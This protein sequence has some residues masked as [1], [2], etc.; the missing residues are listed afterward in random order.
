MSNKEKKEIKGPFSYSGNKFKIWKQHLV[1]PFSK[2]KKIIEPFAGSAVA[3]Y[4]SQEGGLGVDIDPNVFA[5][6]VSLKRPSYMG[7]V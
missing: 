2:Y 6:H 4:N 3:L 1:N 7:K 5:L